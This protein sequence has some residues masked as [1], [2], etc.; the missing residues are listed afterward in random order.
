MTSTQSP[1]IIEFLGSGCVGILQRKVLEER[2]LWR[3]ADTVADGGYCGLAG[4]ESVEVW[5]RFTKIILEGGSDKGRIF[6]TCYEPRL[7]NLA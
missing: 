4:G 6:N 7:H 2:A 1:V 3:M 5:L